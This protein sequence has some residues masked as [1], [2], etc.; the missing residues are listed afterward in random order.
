MNRRDLMK[1]LAVGAA[2]LTSPLG[3]SALKP[4]GSLL[5][6]ATVGSDVLGWTITGISGIERG[7]FHVELKNGDNTARIGVCALGESVKAP[8]TTRFTEVFV[9]NDGKGSTPTDERD[10]E[11]ARIVGMLI[12]GNESEAL[13]RKLL[14]HE[15]RLAQYGPE[16]L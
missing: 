1:S 12:E 2:A 14:T 8:V 5:A 4:S 10:A 7:G 15:Q 6:P 11:A 9:V 13:T 3:A 16:V